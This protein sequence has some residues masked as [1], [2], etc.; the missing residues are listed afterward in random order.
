MPSWLDIQLWVRL[1]PRQLPVVDGDAVMLWLGAAFLEMVVNPNI[2]AKEGFR[3]QRV[4]FN[5]K[6]TMTNDS[7]QS[8]GE[9]NIADLEP[10]DYE[11]IFEALTHSEALY[12]YLIR[13]NNGGEFTESD[14]PAIGRYE[15]SE[16]KWVITLYEERQNPD[17]WIRSTEK[18]P[19]YQP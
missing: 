1:P 14:R 3:H 5:R 10:L 19:A 11:A 17:A 12:H 15:D 13:V 18:V 9:P 4:P 2:A 6:T 8:D 16:T 7:H